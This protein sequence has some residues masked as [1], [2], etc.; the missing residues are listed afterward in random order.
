[1]GVQPNFEDWLAICNVKARY[2][3][4]LDKKDWAGWAE[5]FTEDLVVDTTEAGGEVTTDRASFI[6]PLSQLLADVKTCHQVHSPMIEI[7]GDK[8][9]VIWAMQDRLIWP[10]GNTM[11]GFGHYTEV[12]RR[13]SDGWKIASTKLT[14]LIVDN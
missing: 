10:D 5:I 14:R 11:T 8:A 13:M 12:Y 7:D 1:M 3:Y 6:G 2:C 4:H 9:D